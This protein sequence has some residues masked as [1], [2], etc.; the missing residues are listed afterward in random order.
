MSA[1]GY[2]KAECPFCGQ[3]IELPDALVAEWITCPNEACGKSF[4]PAVKK[5]GALP[6]EFALPSAATP[7]PP[8]SQAI[9]DAAETKSKLA[10]KSSNSAVLLDIGAA[11]LLLV[12]CVMVADGCTAS[13]TEQHPEAGAIRQITATVEAG[14]GVVVIS[15]SLILAA[16]F[17]IIRKP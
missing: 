1:P 5:P 3:H 2:T 8:A 16:L 13:V 15:L 14:L 11:A 4:P 7:R 12:G 17:R 6:R 10:A 9:K